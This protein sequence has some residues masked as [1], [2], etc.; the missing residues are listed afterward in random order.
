MIDDDECILEEFLAIAS[1]T[2]R[3]EIWHW[4][5]GRYSI[6]VAGLMNDCALRCKS[7]GK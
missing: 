3:E 2:F 5:D 7:G 1:G 6:G 4:F